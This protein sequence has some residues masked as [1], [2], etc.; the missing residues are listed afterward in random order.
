MIHN[1][2]NTSGSLNAPVKPSILTG[3]Y[4]KEL[5]RTQMISSADKASTLKKRSNSI[6]E[7]R[8]ENKFSS[9][10][11]VTM[12]LIQILLF[13][14]NH[15]PVHLCVYATLYGGRV[16]LTISQP[17]SLYYKGRL[18]LGRAMGFKPMA[19]DANCTA[20]S[21]LKFFDFQ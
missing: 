12:M 18:L 15:Y 21:S 6:S 3:R 4:R 14:T 1:Y 2:Q 8:H 10:N 16:K 19:L 11:N 9:S 7:C 20:F 17:M 13:C 5:Q